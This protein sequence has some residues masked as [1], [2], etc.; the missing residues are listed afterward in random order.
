[1]SYQRSLRRSRGLHSLRGRR[2]RGALRAVEQACAAGLLVRCHAMSARHGGP[3]K[4]VMLAR[5]AG[6]RGLVGAGGASIAS[7]DI[8]ACRAYE[9]TAACGA[10][11]CSESRGSGDKCRSQRS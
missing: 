7:E 11:D 3:V 4:P 2:G 10:P 8:E 9:D 1:M 6:L 5:P